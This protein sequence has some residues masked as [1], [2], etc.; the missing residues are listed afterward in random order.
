MKSS[1]LTPFDGTFV[2][3]AATSLGVTRL[4]KLLVITSK[5]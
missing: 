2:L 5:N 3:V 1:K 4:V